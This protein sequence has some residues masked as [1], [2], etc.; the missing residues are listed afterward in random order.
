M[1]GGAGAAL[2]QQRTAHQRQAAVAGGRR[3][4]G[5]LLQ[6]RGS[7]R[8]CW[9]PAASPLGSPRPLGPQHALW[10][11]VPHTASATRRHQAR[12]QASSHTCT[13]DINLLHLPMSM[14]TVAVARA[15]LERNAP[16][17]ACE[18]PN[19]NVRWCDCRT[20]RL[21]LIIRNWGVRQPAECDTFLKPAGCPLGR[22]AGG[23]AGPQLGVMEAALLRAW[24][25]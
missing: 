15:I 12:T 20:Q 3:Y 10:P 19:C 5:R 4:G 24:Q 2:Q 11:D 13:C 9:L 21:A 25:R 16:C 17:S 23:Q 22:H 14:A 7:R 6:R 1:G 8:Y 18:L